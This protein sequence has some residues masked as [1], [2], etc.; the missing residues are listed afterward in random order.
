MICPLQK[1]FI[2]LLT[3]VP[4]PIEQD[5]PFR[6]LFMSSANSNFT[7]LISQ[8]EELSS[9]SNFIYSC[10]LPTMFCPSSV[11]EKLISDFRDLNQGPKSRLQSSRHSTM[12]P[13]PSQRP[14]ILYTILPAG[15]LCELPPK[16]RSKST[17]VNPP[18]IASTPPM[19]QLPSPPPPR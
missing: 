14:Y 13:P 4:P 12:S 18:Q 1:C 9:V 5:W 19:F 7:V 17:V 10:Y 3:H 8:R 15:A 6:W 2:S 16:R 11:K